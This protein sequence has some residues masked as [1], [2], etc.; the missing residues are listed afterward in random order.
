MNTFLFSRW[1]NQF[2]H[3]ERTEHINKNLITWGEITIV[4]NNNHQILCVIY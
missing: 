1:K 3:R 4:H 2:I